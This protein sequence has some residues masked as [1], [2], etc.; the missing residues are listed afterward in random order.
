M[1]HHVSGLLSI[2]L[3]YLWSPLASFVCEC[4]AN[5]LTTSQSQFFDRSHVVDHGTVIMSIVVLQFTILRSPLQSQ[6]YS[7]IASHAAY[8]VCVVVTSNRVEANQGVNGIPTL[9]CSILYNQGIIVDCPK[10]CISTP[11]PPPS[12]IEHLFPRT[13][14]CFCFQR[15]TSKRRKRM[16]GSALDSVAWQSAQGGFFHLSR[17]ESEQM[18]LLS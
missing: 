3:R 1:I 8:I 15:T 13:L 18:H 5:Y 12:I 17:D 9:T 6:V 4:T 14:R 10:Q 11:S 7:L 2:Y 16:K